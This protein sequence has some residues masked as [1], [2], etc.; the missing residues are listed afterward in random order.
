MKRSTAGFTLVELLVVILCS[1][2]VTVT[3]MSFLLM[4]MRM[5]GESNDTAQRQQTTRIILTML[6]DLAGSGQIRE[7]RD[8]GESGWAVLDGSESSQPLLRYEPDQKTIVSGSGTVL[9]ENITASTAE[10][11]PEQKLLRFTFTSKKAVYETSIYCRMG[12]KSNSTDKEEA[13]AL[14]ALALQP[15]NAPPAHIQNTP[16]SGG[17]LGSESAAQ[18]PAPAASAPTQRE[19]RLMLLSVLAEQH[20]SGGEIQNQPA[21]APYRYFS[22]WYIGGYG[23]D[24]PGWNTDTPW[25]A[26]FVSWAAA[27]LGD[28][29]LTAVPRF[30]NVDDGME[31]FQS[32]SIGAWYGRGYVPTPGD[33]IFF[34]WSGGN[35]PA[36]V[37]VVFYVDEDAGKVYTIEGNSGSRV[38]L[39]SYARNDPCILGYGVLKWK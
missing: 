21:D 33:C 27:Q 16:T 13:D 4:G 12:V 26:C 38:A 25:C 39:R 15:Q 29:Y 23:A 18:T 10:Y 2:I 34:D 1:S 22:E 9:M 31:Q 7:V 36:H 8:E 6:E 30:C 28:A 20:G 19:S 3:A 11:H 24:K 35:D 5:T 37:G 32:G 14:M 17:S